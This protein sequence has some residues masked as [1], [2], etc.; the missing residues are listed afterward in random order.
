M[1]EGWGFYWP[2]YKT[3]YCIKPD[4]KKIKHIVK[5]NC[6]YVI[7]YT[8]A[9]PVTA[10]PANNK[11]VPVRSGDVSAVPSTSQVPA[12]APEVV[13]EIE[14]VLDEKIEDRGIEVELGLRSQAKSLKHLLTHMPNN[15]YCLLHAR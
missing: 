15:P 2:P 9:G 6:T 4:G 7:D 1:E 10:F 13:D 14:V 11:S 8:A 12:P 3:P 5:H